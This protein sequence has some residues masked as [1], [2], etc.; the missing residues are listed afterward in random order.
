MTLTGD[1]LRAVQG[2]YTVAPATAGGDASPVPSALA[3]G[4]I[5]TSAGVA[6]PFDETWRSIK[7]TSLDAAPP[8]SSSSPPPPPPPLRLRRRATTRTQTA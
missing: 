7:V 3:I 8:P 2:D 4:L 6:T 5:G 1:L